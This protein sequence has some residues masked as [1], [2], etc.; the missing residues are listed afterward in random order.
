MHKE[1][2]REEERREISKYNQLAFCM[3][4]SAYFQGCPFGI[5]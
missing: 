4:L 3:L 1:R 2:V 5:G